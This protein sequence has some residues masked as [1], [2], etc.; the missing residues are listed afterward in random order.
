MSTEELTPDEQAAIDEFA[1]MLADPSL[2][3][4][5][6]AELESSIRAAITTERTHVQVQPT[7]ASPRRWLHVAGGIAIGVAASV[8]AVAF[9]NRSTEPSPGT[10]VSLTATELA[11]D[12]TGTVTVTAFDSGVE[13]AIRAPGLPRRDGLDFYEGWVKN[14]AGDQLVP[15]GTFHDLS[16]AVGWAGVSTDDF[17]IM[18]VTREAAAPPKDAAQGSSGEV[19]VIAAVGPACP[20]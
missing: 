20:G 12:I 6:S 1:A 4:E 9:I 17:P 5:P 7:S 19:V 10:T 16:D 3:D 18:T 11:P 15:I 2:W 13:F 8:A 14:C